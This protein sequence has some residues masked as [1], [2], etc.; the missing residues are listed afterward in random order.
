MAGNLTKG[1]Y[2]KKENDYNRYLVAGAGVSGRNA[3]KLLL[4]LGK[5][6]VLYDNNMNLDTEALTKELGGTGKLSFSLGEI[7]DETL[8]NVDIC[9]ISPGIPLD[10]FAAVRIRGS[11]LGIW[12]WMELSW[13]FMKG[14]LVAITGTNGKTTT[15]TLTSHIFADNQESVFA[16][17]NIG[18]AFTSQVLNTN[19]NS[20]TVAEVSS[21]QLEPIKKFRPTAAAI[22]NITP[23]HLNRHKT[24]DNYVRAKEAIAMNMDKDDICVLNH[25]DPRLR[26]FAKACPATVRF[27]SSEH[28][29]PEGAFVSGG[30]IYLRKNGIDEMVC[31]THSLKIIGKHNYENVCAAVLLGDSL[32]VPMESI[33]RSV[34]AFTA[35]EHRIEYVREKNGVVYYNDSKGTNPDAS[36]QAIKA[37]KRPTILIAGGYDKGSDYDEWLM[38]CLPKTRK[39]VLVGATAKKIGEAAQRIGISQIE[40][41]D[42]FDD[43]VRVCIESARPGDAVLLSPACAS[44]GMF[45]NYEVRGRRF[46]ELVN[47]L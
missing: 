1:G 32:G 29:L 4:Q 26:E 3:C 33:R 2:M 38:A 42:S 7:T 30:N 22:L 15:T 19:E 24:M 20:V 12:S 25:E 23:D 21:F 27:F 8:E 45:P 17:G 34:L 35:V 36:I 47:E 44:W 40:Y 14:R 18:T 5:D 28:E 41:A 37:M 11:G 10:S 13:R 39:L 43:A 46:K 6:V 31:S 16:V 9:V